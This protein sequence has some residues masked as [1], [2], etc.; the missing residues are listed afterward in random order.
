MKVDALKP[1]P[2]NHEAFRKNRERFIPQGSGC[3]VLTTFSRDVLYVG[4]ASSLR[5]RFGQHLENPEKNVITPVGRAILFWWLESN[6]I[7]KLERTWMNIHMLAE[8]SL[9]ILNKAY[10]PTRT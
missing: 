3:Y 9:P 10:S 6:E 4:L 2:K 8:A 7:N 5:R 1:V